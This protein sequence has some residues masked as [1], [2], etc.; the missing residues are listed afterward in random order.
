[1]PLP[2]D[3][4]GMYTADGLTHDQ[5]G[6]PSSSAADHRAHLEKLRQKLIGYEYGGAWAHF[7]LASAPAPSAPAAEISLVTWGSSWG[8]THEAAAQLRQRGV[9]IQVI[10]LRLIAPLD[11]EALQGALRHTRVLVVEINASGQLFRYLNAQRSLPQTAESFARSGPL[12]LRPQEIIARL[13]P[14]L[15]DCGRETDR[16]GQRLP[17]S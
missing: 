2:G 16:D 9:R 14:L 15:A 10:G 12:S 17:L 8:A 5:R 6:T 1:M 4:G 13:A 7:D 11:T 3:V